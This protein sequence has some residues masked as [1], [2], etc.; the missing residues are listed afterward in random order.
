VRVLNGLLSDVQARRSR[1]LVVQ[2]EAGIGK[3]ALLGL[4]CRDRSGFPGG[5]G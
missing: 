1:V 4:R 3:T 2:G 5:P